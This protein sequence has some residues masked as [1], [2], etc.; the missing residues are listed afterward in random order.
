MLKLKY[1]QK[2]FVYLSGIFLLFT[3]LVLFLQYNREKAFKREQ[4]EMNLDNIAELTYNYIEKKNLDPKTS[5]SQLDSLYYYIPTNNIR[6]TIINMLGKV[7]YDS[8]VSDP[9]KMENHLHRPEIKLAQKSGAGS[10]IR[11]SST[12]GYEYYYYAKN[13]ENMFVRVAAHY[14]VQV[15]NFMH[16]EKIFLLYL[17]VLFLVT[18]GI[19]SL[20]LRNL[21]GVLLKLKDF[22]SRLSKGE[23]IEEK[24][25]FPDGEF[26]EISNQIVEIYDK[27]TAAKSTIEIEK[28][29]MFSHLIALNEG[30]AFYT[31]AKKKILRNN[32]FIQFINI[33][34]KKSNISEEDIF[35]V[36]EFSK[37]N[38]FLDVYLDEDK[39]IPQNDLPHFED[40]VYRDKRTFNL[41]AIVFADRSFEVVIRD[42]TKLEKQKRIK[43]EITSNIAHE[44]KTPITIVL[45]YLELLR[46]ND[47]NPEDTKKYIRNAYTQSER[48]SD[49]IEDITLLQKMSEAKDKFSFEAVN[50][51]DLIYEVKDS[52]A[53]SMK[54]KNCD[55]KI[56]LPKPIII[57]A[58]RS[59]L[60][61]VFYNLF[62]N[63]IKYG[64]ENIEISVNNYLED[65]NY[66]YFSFSNTGTSIDK[67]HFLRIFE[68]FYRVDDDRSREKGGTG[69]GLA[70]VKNAIQLHGGEIT[71]GN[72]KNGGVEF[73]FTLSKSL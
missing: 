48:L 64:G 55:V 35:E 15:K 61:S 9:S 27:L 54:E 47:I 66:Y 63:A 16:I 21:S 3:T 71:A 6:I 29:K 20:V 17:L 44:L 45:G 70:I 57:N 33:I 10:H 43:E 36:K 32:H 37:L 46:N 51:N 52:L 73:L 62:D 8:E 42:I 26:G 67:K 31:P 56:R 7:L 30:I 18:W 22:A 1:R 13:Y 58:N 49:L 24:I 25:V 40:V 28:N 69:L 2:L 72:H 53:L 65:S 14:D 34:S 19:L 5:Y 12:T 41:H 23:E 59:L 50:L 39:E 68:R 4:M 60:F 38:S 11:E